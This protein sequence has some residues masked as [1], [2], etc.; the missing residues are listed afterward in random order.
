MLPAIEA[1]GAN[2]ARGAKDARPTGMSSSL[3]ESIIA[4][5]RLRVAA[6]VLLARVKVEAR[7]AP[8]GLEAKLL[9][10]RVIPSRCAHMPEVGEKLARPALTLAN[11]RRPMTL[12]RPVKAGS[13]SEESEIA[14][15]FFFCGTKLRP[16]TVTTVR[17]LSGVGER[18]TREMGAAKV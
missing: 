9:V 12:L 1:R 11:E 13:S 16:G 18:D 5:L 15:I 3:S 2:E 7:S 10:L 14:S 4:A 8:N 6:L 17:R